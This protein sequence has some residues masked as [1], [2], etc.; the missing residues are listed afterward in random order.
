MPEEI[1]QNMILNLSL[2]S[3]NQCYQVLSG[4]KYCGRNSNSKPKDSAFEIC[5]LL[6]A[7]AA[8]SSVMS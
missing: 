8:S 2:D 3:T 7:N 1:T 4:L 5:L 6:R